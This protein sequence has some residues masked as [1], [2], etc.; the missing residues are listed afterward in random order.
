MNWKWKQAGS[1]LNITE[2]RPY[3]KTVTAAVIMALISLGSV[4]MAESGPKAS[5]YA[6]VFNADQAKPVQ[7]VESRTAIVPGESIID[8]DVR[9]AKEK[10]E[11][12]AQAKKIASES[13]REVISRES[14]TTSVPSDIDLIGV[15]KSAAATYGIADWRY[16]K[17]VHYVET[18]C[19]VIQIK[20]SSA[21]ATGPMQ[22]L[23][24]TWRRWG[25]DGNGDGIADINNVIDAIYGAARYLQVSGGSTDIT[26]ALY[27]Y[28][29]SS[30]YV[31]KV[32]S[33]ALSISQ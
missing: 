16:L 22:F 9:L 11:A 12:E 24:S 4:V 17:A 1:Q 13:Q 30:S 15:Y 29:H 26:K 8:R 5:D 2:K 33:V 20:K 25:V 3:F 31:R 21:G 28:N 14:R 19:A 7:I 32:T 6:I 23:P 27:S 18:G 10:A